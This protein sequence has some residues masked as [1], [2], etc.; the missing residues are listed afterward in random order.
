MGL[1]GICLGVVRLVERL[2]LRLADRV[3]VRAVAVVRHEVVAGV[4]VSDAFLGPDLTCM[5]RL[6]GPQADV[7]AAA[8]RLAVVR[9]GNSAP[10]SLSADKEKQP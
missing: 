8:A 3:R 10:D 4:V 7:P 2:E 9:T 5:L 6:L 1:P